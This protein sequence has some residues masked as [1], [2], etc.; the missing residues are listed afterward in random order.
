MKAANEYRAKAFEC[1]SFAEC[2]NNP[3]VT[4]RDAPVCANVDELG[5]TD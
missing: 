1:L 2:M 4:R 3:E 5:R